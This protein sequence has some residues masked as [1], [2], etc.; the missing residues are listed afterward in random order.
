MLAAFE[1]HGAAVLDSDAVV[2]DLY[3]RPE[4]RDVIVR[5][6]G[7]DVLRVDGTV[8]RA[9]VAGMAFSSEVERSWLEGVLHPLVDETF[10]AWVSAVRE[11]APVALVH[12]VALLFEVGLE[13]RYDHVI[14]VDAPDADRAARVASRGG[15]VALRERER[16]FL[17]VSEKRRRASFVIDNVSSLDA[18]DAAVTAI[19]AE[20]A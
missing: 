6:L 10:R 18:V 11:R 3:A 5:H 16:R 15:L 17:P 4:V 20:I 7:P 8:D 14:V 19:L 12:E 2:R 9:R 1:R 13:A